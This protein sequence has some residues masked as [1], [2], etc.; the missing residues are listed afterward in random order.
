MVSGCSW[1]NILIWE[2]GLIKVEVFR[3]LRKT[4][5]Q[6][7]IVQFEF[8]NGELWSIAMDGRVR[9]WSYDV[10]DQA[11]PP[12]ED[13]VVLIEPVYDFYTPDVEFMCVYK[14]NV[15]PD[16]TFYIAQV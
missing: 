14:L 10:I 16:D 13:R 8:K 7:P 2:A 11:D 5:H 15:D 9:V 6:A 1:G 12:D 3:Q 4:C